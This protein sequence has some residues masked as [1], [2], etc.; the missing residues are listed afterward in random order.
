M[1]NLLFT[2]G[3]LLFTANLI[4]AHSG[5]VESTETTILT[6]NTSKEWLAN[7]NAQLLAFVVSKAEIIVDYQ[8]IDEDILKCIVTISVT[9]RDP[10]TGSTATAT[11]TVEGPCDEVKAAAM[12]LVKDLINEAK[13][14][15]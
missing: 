7:D 6:A 1:K 10:L 4:F 8:I 14:L 13:E 9:I 2:I 5:K 3:I 11:G 12:A 15:L